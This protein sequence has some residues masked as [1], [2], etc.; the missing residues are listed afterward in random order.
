MTLV[1][2]A[3]PA[4]VNLRLAV[5]GRRSDGYHEIDSLVVFAGLADTLALAPAETPSFAAT[6]EFSPSLPGPGPD[7]NIVDRAVGAFHAATGLSASYAIALEKNI[8]VAAGLGGGSA[9]AAAALVHLNRIH[10][11][12]LDAEELE[13]VGLSV[14]ADVPVCLRDHWGGHGGGHGSGW[15]MRGAG[16]VLDKVDLPEGLGLVLVNG[17]QAVPTESV[18][19]ALEVAPGASQGPA[20]PLGIDALAELVGLGNDLREAAVSLCPGIGDTLK[21]V[22]GLSGAGGFVGAGMSGSGATCFALFETR[23]GAEAAAPLVGGARWCWAGGL[24]PG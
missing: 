19:A 1:E 23:A 14:G 18:F 20:G 5:T 6:G 13:R 12:P 3:A 7:S 4:K 17:G 11:T 16:E 22:E 9:D 21:A 10:G 8:P 2:L 15:R 24:Y